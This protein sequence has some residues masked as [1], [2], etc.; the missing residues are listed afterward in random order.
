MISV[1]DNTAA[2]HL[3]FRLGRENVEAFQATMGHGDPARN[4]PFLATREMG[5]LKLVLA[6]DRVAAYLAASVAEKRRLLASE[7][8]AAP[9]DPAAVAGWTAPRSIDRLEWFASAEDLCR[10][11]AA[12]LVM[13]ERPG[14]EPLR[15]V[16]AINPG[17]PF[18]PNTWT[19]IG[20]KGGGEPGVANGTW[21]LRRADG[22]W[23]VLTSGA[24][25][26]KEPL[27]GDA[28]IPLMNDAAALLAATR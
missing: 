14:L 4:V 5:V 27:D 7:I 24:N 6:P 20:F 13:S 28:G 16:L 9:V 25:D 18:D 26:P 2:D 8:A 23:F 11:M 3:L 15:E 10:A 21:L 12:L 22:R 1:S 17:I 19:Y